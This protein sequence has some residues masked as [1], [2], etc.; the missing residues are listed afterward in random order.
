MGTHHSKP[1]WQLPA[2]ELAHLIRTGSVSSEDVIT[3]HLDRLAHVNPSLNAVVVERADEALQEA[4]AAD[5][6]IALIVR[7]R[8]KIR[9]DLDN[10]C[11]AARELAVHTGWPTIGR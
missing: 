3:A 11:A 9:S 1:L 2:T 8:T 7:I 5:E 4:K 6:L 10:L